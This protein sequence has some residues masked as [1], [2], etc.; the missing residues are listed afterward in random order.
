[1]FLKELDTELATKVLKCEEVK[2]LGVKLG[3]EVES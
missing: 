3:L 2:A 1:M